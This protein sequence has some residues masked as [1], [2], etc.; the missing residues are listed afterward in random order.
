MTYKIDQIEGIG[1]HYAERL[2]A[3]G[4]TTTDH[5]LSR[6]ATLAGRQALEEATGISNTLIVTWANQADLMRI[7]GV[8][9]EFGQL[10]ESA[11]V[12][13]V[14]ELAHR[15]PENLVVAMAHVNDLK[16]LTRVVPTVKVVSKRVDQAKTLEPVL[17]H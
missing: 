2:G 4:L 12:D 14:K 3:V 13:T 6:C 9:S 5:L 15:R 16:H 11:G 10:L 7:S 17:S 1:P 8:G